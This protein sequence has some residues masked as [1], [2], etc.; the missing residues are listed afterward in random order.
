MQGCQL[1]PGAS[2]PAT[3]HALHARAAICRNFAWITLS[4]PPPLSSPPLLK[5]APRS[6]L[7]SPSPRRSSHPPHGAT[8]AGLAVYPTSQN[9]QFCGAAPQKGVVCAVFQ[10]G[11]MQ[12]KGRNAAVWARC[13]AARGHRIEPRHLPASACS[14]ASSWPCSKPWSLRENPVRAPRLQTFARS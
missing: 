7:P 12:Q 2:A 4:R 1:Q 13:L 11:A 14:S 5:F 10:K 9:G 6:A 3:R 8:N